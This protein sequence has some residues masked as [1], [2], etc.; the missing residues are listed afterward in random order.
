[1]RVGTFGK[2]TQIIEGS[3]MGRNFSNCF[4]GFLEDIYI[5]EIPVD[6]LKKNKICWYGIN[7]NFI[8]W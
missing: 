1:M 3:E 7:I 4:W 5:I 6:Q 2:I 8:M